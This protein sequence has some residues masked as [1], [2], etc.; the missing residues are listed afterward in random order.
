MDFRDWMELVAEPNPSIQIVIDRKLKF[1]KMFDIGRLLDAFKAR[2]RKIVDL[3]LGTP[4]TNCVKEL[5]E[6]PSVAAVKSIQLRS[7][8]GCH[9]RT[10]IKSLVLTS[11]LALL[12]KQLAIEH[13]ISLSIDMISV[14]ED[15]GAL[16]LASLMP[17]I[18]SLALVPS[19]VDRS[20]VHSAISS[21]RKFALSSAALAAGP[22]TIEI[23]VSRFIDDD[24]EEIEGAKS[25]IQ[26]LS[27]LPNLRELVIGNLP[28]SDDLRRSVTSVL[29]HK[30]CNIK[31]LR[32]RID[33]FIES[34]PQE[35]WKLLEQ[36]CASL[37]EVCLELHLPSS[38][39]YT[40]T[41]SH[42][43]R[44]AFAARSR[45][46]KVY[47]AVKLALDDDDMEEIALCNLGCLRGVIP[48]ESST[49][50][51]PNE[52]RSFSIFMKATT[53]N[54]EEMIK[55]ISS[56]FPHLCDLGPFMGQQIEGA[57]EDL[58]PLRLCLERNRV[59]IGFLNKKGRHGSENDTSLPSGLW[60]LLLAKHHHKDKLLV[61]GLYHTLK[62]LAQGGLLSANIRGSSTHDQSTQR[63]TKRMRLV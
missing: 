18:Q 41:A 63:A 50:K 31:R 52:L 9:I 42:A 37:E 32:L 11:E 22:E 1:D 39:L 10:K 4:L 7:V 51:D 62:E 35:Y 15:E 46:R 29:T 6:T 3:V 17:H 38:A 28:D 30:D 27:G 26:S 25:H 14:I 2:G 13:Q 23:K 19:P 24:I 21:I 61:D 60:P 5:L 34:G 12:L 16:A 57:G 44:L 48:D 54:C 55:M 56:H 59:G 20:V 36:K 45:V 8:V 58:L 53:E 43:L 40:S 47:I 33:D 49:G